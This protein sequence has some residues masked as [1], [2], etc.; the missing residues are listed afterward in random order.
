MR[1]ALLLRFKRIIFSNEMKSS[2]ELSGNMMKKVSS[3]GD[4]LV[5]R[6]HNQEETPFVPHLLYFC[7]AN[8]IPKITPFDNAINDI[9]LVII[10]SSLLNHRMNLN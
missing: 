9:L 5:G 1:W 4:E 8:D 7:M 6:T 2:S 3:G 10:K